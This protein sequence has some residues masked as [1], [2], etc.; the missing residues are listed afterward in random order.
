METL[1]K[2]A[3]FQSCCST[4]DRRNWSFSKFT[5]FGWC[6]RSL[7]CENNIKNNIINNKNP[8]FMIVGRTFS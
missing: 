7:S 1:A 6:M 3:P 2:G 4:S 8:A 5:I